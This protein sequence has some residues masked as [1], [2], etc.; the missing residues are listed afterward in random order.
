MAM[1]DSL[2]VL[3]QA[4][5]QHSRR[6][7]VRADFDVA[8]EKGRIRDDFRMQ[9]VL[10][11]LEFLL[12]QGCHIRIISHR[13]RP[14]GTRVSSLSMRVVANHLSHLLKKPVI[15]I[16]DPFHKEALRAYDANPNILFF[17]NIRFWAGEEKNSVSFARTLAQWGDIYVNEAFASC[18]R[19]HASMVALP[20]II[21]SYAGFRFE[22]EVHTLER[23]MG[24]PEHPLIA[25]LGG[26]KL[27][28]KIPLIKRF[29]KDADYVLIGGA[30][31]NTLLSMQGLPV[32]RSFIDREK[33]ALPHWLHNKKLSIPVDVVVSKGMRASSPLRVC[34][35]QD[36][37]SNE[38][39]IDIGPKT[40]TH[41][42]KLLTGAKTIIW[43]GPLGY[44][45]ISQFA[46]GTIQVAYCIGRLNAFSVVGGG[47]SIAI[48]R[49]YNALSGFTHISTGGGAML[50]FLIGKKLSA[51]EV[52]K[53]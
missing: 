45:E 10:P 43:N 34:D 16:S 33:S 48:L 52:L 36:V 3:S 24:K 23:V 39:I 7:L 11:V 38:Y 47:D 12:K 15:F 46:K 5:L 19:T 51:V 21:P 4:P 1:L 30:I 6:V 53:K 22:K 27:E 37:K 8:M 14:N 13:G 17:E 9:E 42:I 20:K 40:I 44:A 49:G 28:T 25:I 35:V 41:F 29:L 26:A 2:R 32:G 18:H 31:A 50:E